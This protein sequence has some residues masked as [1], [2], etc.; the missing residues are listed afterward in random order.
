[1]P[2]ARCHGFVLAEQNDEWTEA[3]HDMGCELLESETEEIAL[4]TGLTA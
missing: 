4:P 2:S 1:M 3:R